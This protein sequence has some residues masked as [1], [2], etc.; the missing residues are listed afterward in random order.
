M[1]H[2]RLIAHRGAEIVTREQLAHYVPPPATETF[3]PVGHAELVATLTQ[4]MQDRGLHI[5]REQF[6][7]Q[8]QKLFGT[9]DL[10]WQRMEEYGAA[11]GFRHANDKSMPIQIAVGARVFV[12]DN[13]SFSGEMIHTRRH[14]AK[15]DLGQ[16]LDQAMY[17]YMQGFRKLIDDITVQKETVME[18]RKAKTLIYDIFR[19]KIVPVRLFHPVVWSW[20]DSVKQHEATGWLLHNCFT[21]HIQKLAPAPAFKATARLGKFFASKF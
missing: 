6:A 13:M 16:E 12:C 14:T 7:V 19:Q 3:K 11:V 9:F 1:E 4:V 10:E 5:V 15:L 2:G 8:S 21:Y 20:E 17:R 18:D